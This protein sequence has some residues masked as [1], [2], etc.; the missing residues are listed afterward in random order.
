MIKDEDPE[1][2]ELLANGDGSNLS[3]SIIIDSAKLTSA[4]SLKVNFYTAI[5]F[6]SRKSDWDADGIVASAFDSRLALNEYVQKLNDDPLLAG[7][8]SVDVN[9]SSV[10][11]FVSTE[12]LASKAAPSGSKLY[13]AIGLVG[14]TCLSI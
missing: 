9:S 4:S 5:A 8:Q 12:A 11:G 13:T 1:T 10:E 14:L 2:H 7:V 6:Q 3:V